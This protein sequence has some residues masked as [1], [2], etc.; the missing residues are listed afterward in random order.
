MLA[1]AAGLLYGFFAS[2]VAIPDCWN[3]LTLLHVRQ[4]RRPVTA[5]KLWRVSSMRRFCRSGV[6][7]PTEN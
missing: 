4:Q 1:V 7:T 6:L 2:K 3:P 5:Y